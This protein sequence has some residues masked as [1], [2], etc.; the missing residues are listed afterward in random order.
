MSAKLTQVA[1]EVGV[2]VS[3]VSRAFSRP[4]LLSDA[5][6]ARVMAAADRLGYQ[7]NRFAR[8]L[9]TGRSMNLGLIVPDIAN[10]FFPPLIKAAQEAARSEGYSLYLANTNEDPEEEASVLAHLGSQV[11]GIVLCSPRTTVQR[12]HELAEG[13]PVVLVNRVAR[14]MPAVL[15]DAAT[16]MGEAVDHLAD[17]GHRDLVYVAGPRRSWSNSERLKAV[18]AHCAERDIKLRVLGPYVSSRE[19]GLEAAEQIIGTSA[20]AVIAFDDLLAVGVLLGLTNAGLVIPRDMSIIGCD[21]VV[22]EYSVP[23]LTSIGGGADIAGQ[24]AVE[25][26]LSI[27]ERPLAAYRSRTTLSTRLIVRSSTGPQRRGALPGSRKGRA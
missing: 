16:G 3:T 13:V 22:A 11:D 4:E 10:P 27:L 23:A 5:T 19:A 18:R 14:D 8:A 1:A 25:V 12:V 17:L 15:I 24:V 2:S 6:V 26:L 20:T 21:D 9:I 7:P